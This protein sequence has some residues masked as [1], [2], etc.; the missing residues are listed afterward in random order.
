MS[1]NSTVGLGLFH[2]LF[3]SFGQIKAVSLIDV[4]IANNK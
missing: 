4:P 3:M 2:T 1:G